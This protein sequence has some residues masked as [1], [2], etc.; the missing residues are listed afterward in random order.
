MLALIYFLSIILSLF[1]FPIAIPFILVIWLF[2][3]KSNKNNKEL[4]EIKALLKQNNE[5]NND[6]IL[7]LTK[8]FRMVFKRR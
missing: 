4:Q 7:N 8:K 3:N 1:F 6:Y 5:F 2:T